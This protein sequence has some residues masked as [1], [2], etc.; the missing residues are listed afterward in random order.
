MS[1]SQLSSTY[2]TEEALELE[3]SRRTTTQPALTLYLDLSFSTIICWTFL[4]SYKRNAE[5][6]VSC[7]IHEMTDLKDHWVAKAAIITEWGCV[8]NSKTN[9][10]WLFPEANASSS[11]SSLVSR[12]CDKAKTSK[13]F[14][15]VEEELKLRQ[16][17]FPN[18]KEH[19]LVGTKKKSHTR[20]ISVVGN[21]TKQVFHQSNCSNIVQTLF[22]SLPLYPPFSLNTTKHSVQ[23]AVADLIDQDICQTKA[24]NAEDAMGYQKQ[25]TH[26]RRTT[27]LLC[28]SNPLNKS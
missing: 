20:K 16:K 26:F 27:C 17:R 18:R 14:L 7:F 13:S 28:C 4:Y 2:H 3:S 22:L 10:R 9:Q 21:K 19:F 5:C 8:K 12:R 24:T 11:V 1:A 15:G 25:R 6:L 23:K